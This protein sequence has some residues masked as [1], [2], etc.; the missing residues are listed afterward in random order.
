M[1]SPKHLLPLLSTG[2]PL[3]QHLIGIICAAVPETKTIYI[4][5]GESSELDDTLR[6]G[7]YLSPTKAGDQ[8]IN[9]IK[10]P[11]GTPSNIGPAAGL[12]AAHQ[13][14][15]KAV[16]LVIACD[17]PL[18]AP[19]AL[20][21][22][23]EAF[24]DPVTCFVNKEGFSEPLLAIWSPHALQCLSEN[25]KAGRSGPS[26]TIKHL[27]GKLIQ[28]VDDEWILN[29]NTPEEWEAARLRVR[30]PQPIE[31]VWE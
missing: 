27:N 29:T 20:H 18:L 25:V 14:D 23:R 17:F 24:E 1:G 13:Y 30:A 28:P 19:A 4:S 8:R 6:L 10:I 16:W 11:D 15:P 3:Y 21:Q 2:Q 12:L 7:T 31:G 5:T 22:L 9:L 26:Y